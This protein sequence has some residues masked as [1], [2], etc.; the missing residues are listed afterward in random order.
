MKTVTRSNVYLSMAAMI[1]MA[2]LA[3]PAAAQKQIPFKGTI[4]GNDTDS[5]GPCGAPVANSPFVCVA[6]T[7]TGISTHL[8]QFVFTLQVTVNVAALPF[9]ATGSAH[10]VAAN[11]DSIDMTVTGS[12]EPMATPD[13]VVFNITETYIITG[14]TGRFAGAQG[15]FTMQRVGI[16]APQFI[17]F[18]FFDGTITSPGVAH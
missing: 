9:T 13:G 2:A 16:G 1:L 6:T 10:W 18:G 17:T 14:G 15:H 8:G 11:G 4:Q 7:G 3:I 5:Q 12:G